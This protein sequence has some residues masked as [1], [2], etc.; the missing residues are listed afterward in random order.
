MKKLT[1]FGLICILV[2]GCVSNN[3]GFEYRYKFVQRS[4]NTC[5]KS[6]MSSKKQYSESGIRNYCE[7]AM[8][9]FVAEMSDED[10]IKYE[11]DDPETEIKADKIIDKYSYQCLDKLQKD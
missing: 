5:T 2:A 6:I 7:C 4:V 11:K 10:F 9:K 8:V 1:I 3:R